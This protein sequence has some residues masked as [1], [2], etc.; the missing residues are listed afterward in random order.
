MLMKSAGGVDVEDPGVFVERFFE[1]AGII[2]IE[3]ID[4]E[5]H[6]SNDRVVIIG[7]RGHGGL[8]GFVARALI[9]SEDSTH[10]GGSNAMAAPLPRA[11]TGSFPSREIAIFPA[12]EHWRRL[13]IEHSLAKQI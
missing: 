5:T 11:V 8:L 6:H 3:S 12:N 4:V 9:A 2:V 1:L 7:S 13:T 10:R